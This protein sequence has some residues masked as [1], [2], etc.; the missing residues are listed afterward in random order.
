MAA[1][2]GNCGFSRAVSLPRSRISDRVAYWLVWNRNYGPCYTQFL[3]LV[4]DSGGLPN[5]TIPTLPSPRLN[6]SSEWVW[7]LGKIEPSSWKPPGRR[8]WGNTSQVECRLWFYFV[9][10]IQGKRVVQS[11]T[12]MMISDI[13]S[14]LLSHSTSCSISS[15]WLIV[16]YSCLAGFGIRLVFN[17]MAFSDMC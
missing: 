17:E 1:V 8:Q 2:R 16:Y 11:I 9:N 3:P 5:P 14:L 10:M 6:M 15:T 4:A 13:S 7:F 12:F